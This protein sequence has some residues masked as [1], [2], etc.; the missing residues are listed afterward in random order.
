MKTEEFDTE[1]TKELTCPYCGHI[2]D[3]A[4][5]YLDNFYE[6]EMCPNC[7]KIFTFDIFAEPRY[8]TYKKE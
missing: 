1:Y 2:M 6:E 3:D 7:G 8:F 4:Y 5:D